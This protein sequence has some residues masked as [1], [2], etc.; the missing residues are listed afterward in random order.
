MIYLKAFQLSE[1][2][3][4]NTNVYPYNIFSRKECEWLVF[5]PITVLYG[6]NGSGKSTLLNIMANKLGLKGAEHGKDVSRCFAEYIGECGFLLGEEETGKELFRL[7]PNSR[8]IKSEDI[9]YVVKRTQQ[10]AIL[11]ES[12]LYQKAAE[13]LEETAIQKYADS[14][15]LKKKMDI[16]LFNQEKYSNGETTLQ[17][18]EDSI[19]PDSLYLLDEPEMSLSPQNQVLLA[20]KINEATRYLSCQFIIATH[21]P[22][23]LGTLQGKIM[24]ID[25]KEMSVSSWSELE[26][27]R[28]FYEFF[29]K[30]EQSFL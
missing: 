15:E 22:F 11:K 2:K 7:P 26:N 30:N 19:Y 6:N 24:N 13:G 12:Y 27:V 10:E 16:M 21:S 9:M 28:Y 3:I 20:E 29:K 18:L 4:P 25:T 1:R 23:M 17:I 14:Y 8:Y 5:E